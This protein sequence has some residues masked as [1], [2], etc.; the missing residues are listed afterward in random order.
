MDLTNTPILFLDID[1]VICLWKNY[2]GKQTMHPDWGEISKFDKKSVKVLNKIID[3]TNCEIVVSS[4]WKRGYNLKELQDIFEWNNI[5]KK[6]IDCTVNRLDQDKNYEI[7]SYVNNHELKKW[8]AIDDLPL[9]VN[10]F[11]QCKR[12]NEGIKQ[13]GIKEKVMK[14]LT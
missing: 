8:V 12:Q 14:Y 4:D 13:T 3:E 2:L 1:D 11:V 5:N 7:I 9:W 10:N 6:P